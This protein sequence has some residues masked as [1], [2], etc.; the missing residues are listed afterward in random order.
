MVS[1]Q[2]RGPSKLAMH[3]QWMLLGIAI[4]VSTVAFAAAKTASEREPTQA[5]AVDR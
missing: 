1:V 4:G 3:L 2:R 5:A